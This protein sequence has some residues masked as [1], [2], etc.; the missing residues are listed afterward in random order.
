MPVERRLRRLL[1]AAL[2]VPVIVT[3]YAA[4]FA[5]RLW[6]VLR[7]PV[8]TV[9][10]ATVIGS[11]YAEEAWRHAPTPVRIAPIR[12]AAVMALALVFA[13]AALPPAPAHAASPLRAVL[14]RAREYIGTPYKLGAEQRDLVD[15]SGL[16]F[17]IFADVGELPRIGGKRLRSTGYYRWF[18]ARGLASK[19]AADAEPGDFIFYRGSINHIG[20]YIG[21][22][23]VLSALVSGVKIHDMFGISVEFVAVLKVNYTVGDPAPEPEPEPA[24][25]PEPGDGDGDG[26]EPGDGDGSPVENPGGKPKDNDKPDD[27]TGTESGDGK[28]RGFA[29]GT[30]NLRASADP[31]ARIIGWVRRGST[32]S[33]LGEGNSPSGALWFEVRTRSGQT[34]WVYARWAR[35]LEP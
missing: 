22:G 30:M 18:A 7:P 23:K 11:V 16:L 34:G 28:P 3:V 32:F 27:R 26:G 1:V 12:S 5:G 35:P 17:R 31:N 25:E 6:A 2:A 10:G 33:L 13:S 19:K 14:D 8:A 29:V 24:P 21:D 4:A 15:C 20:I 9:L